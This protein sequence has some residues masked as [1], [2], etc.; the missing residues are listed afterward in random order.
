MKAQNS[1]TNKTTNVKKQDVAFSAIINSPACRAM[2]DKSVGDSARAAS[3]ISTLIEVVNS[4]TQLLDIAQNDPGSIISAALRGEIGMGLSLALGEYSIVPYGKKASFQLSANGLKQLAIRSG[5]YSAIDVFEV[6]EGEYKGRD[7]LTREPIIHWLEDDNKR[8][9]LPIVG[10]Y[11]FY[12][13][14]KA[15]NEFFQCVYWTHEKILDHA[16]K[17]SKAFS[18]EKYKALCEGKLSKDEVAKLQAGSPWYGL[19]DSVPHMKMCMK[20]L[21]KQLL[22]DGRAPKQ[23]FQ[24]IE[25]DNY[26]EKSGE[27]V[28]ATDF[29]INL[30]TQTGEV[31]ESADYTVKEHDF[32]TPAEG[33]ES[34]SAANSFFDE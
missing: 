2:I 31:I 6:R 32:D 22:G 9:E 3:L 27:A 15:Y 13:L 14:G 34:A 5:K 26:E 19:P 1:I 16:D 8:E 28:I 25:R 29:N 23:I 7:R 12:K 33:D 4:K 10:Y 30:D 17:Y 11:G 18:A 20:T 21:I 24:A